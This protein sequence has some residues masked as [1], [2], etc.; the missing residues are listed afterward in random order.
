MNKRL[1]SDT[2]SLRGYCKK[3]LS[4]TRNILCHKEHRIPLSQMQFEIQGK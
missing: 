3:V 1:V 2:K 4:I